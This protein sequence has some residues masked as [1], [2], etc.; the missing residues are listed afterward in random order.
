M[1]P[2]SNTKFAITALDD[3]R[4]VR[5]Q[6]FPV[7]EVSQFATVHHHAPH[8]GVVAGGSGG[9]GKAHHVGQQ[10]HVGALGERGDGKREG[11]EGEAK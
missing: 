10:A 6:K 7:E 8:A 2:K 5:G 4:V 11:S 3:Q 1:L 9:A